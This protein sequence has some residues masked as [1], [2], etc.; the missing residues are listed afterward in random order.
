MARACNSDE[1]APLNE[2]DGGEFTT[3]DEFILLKDR[4]KTIIIDDINT[5]KGPL[6]HN[7][8]KENSDKYQIIMEHPERNGFLVAKRTT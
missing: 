7:F 8:L 3:Y 6:I 4:F 2:L 1:L 5:Q